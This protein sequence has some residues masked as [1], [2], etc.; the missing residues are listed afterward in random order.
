M[1]AELLLSNF[2][3]IIDSP[4]KVSELRKLILQLAVQGKLVDQDSSDEP[5]SV[6]L[7]H[8][9]EEKQKLLKEKAIRKEKALAPIEEDDIPFD[10]PEGWV[11][12]RMGNLCF[13]IT[14]GAHHTPKYVDSGVPFLSVKDMSK[15]FINLSNTRFISQETHEELIKR[16]HPQFEDVL[17]TKVGTTGIAKVIDVELE[18]SIFVSLAL[19]QFNR[20]CIYPYYLEY[21]INSPLV[22]EKSKSGTKG[23]GNKNL[24]LKTIKNF[25]V[26]LPPKNEQERIVARI[27]QMMEYCDSL[28]KKLEEEAKLRVT[29]NKSALYHLE[30][31]EDEESFQKNFSVISRNFG[32]LYDVP[33]N[34][35]QLKQSI[36]RLAVQ[37]RL[38]EQDS[39]DEPASVLLER[40]RE[41]KERLI[42]EKVIKKDKNLSPIEGDEVPF[43]L[44]KAWEWS[45]LGHILLSIKYGTSKKCIL[46]EVG[47]PI[48]RI[49]NVS[50]GRINLDEVKYTQLD[51]KEFDSLKLQEGD[52]LLIRSN[53]SVSLVGRTTL[54]NS[55]I[56]NYAYAGYLM[57]LRL[58]PDFINPRYLKLCMDSPYIRHLIEAPI[59]T[60]T[61]VHNI[62]S[63]EV[64]N[65]KISVPP[66]EEQLR[67]V[68]KVNQLFN[69]CNETQ[70]LMEN[71]QIIHQKMTQ[72]LMT[73]IN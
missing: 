2:D 50:K 63:T 37:G 71:S 56:E 15:G 46:D 31:S 33:E 68:T 10:I 18:F 23:I 65:L 35:A 20:D 43:Q 47:T 8:I 27:K 1:S 41:E 22:K 24:V 45:R 66:L 16:C 13:R 30:T 48:L 19:L 60:T 28:Q 53:G 5:A 38:V 73:A 4:E 39:D 11:W 3:M 61:G 59:R 25:A 9:Q 57:R 54:V 40:I 14:D 44:P 34:V 42:K 58:N 26:P 29:L 64:S 51:A 6:L 7:M 17:L 49:P 52:L 62:N 55:T 69:F 32:M 21:L 70:K 72:S 36:L 67:I 12:E